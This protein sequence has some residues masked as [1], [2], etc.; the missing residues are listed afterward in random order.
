[1][2]SGMFWHEHSRSPTTLFFFI[3]VHWMYCCVYYKA[4]VLFACSLLETS[5]FCLVSQYKHSSSI[6]VYW[7]LWGH[8]K[9]R[10]S[11]ILGW[12]LSLACFVLLTRH[13]CQGLESFGQQQFPTCCFFLSPPNRPVGATVTACL[14]CAVS[15]QL[16]LVC[17]SDISFL[18]MM[19][20]LE[21]W[22]LQSWRILWWL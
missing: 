8:F 11:S 18:C 6:C 22:V 14:L 21:S 4:K 5:F 19:P 7:G 9:S 15:C 17:V 13:K 2:H 1:M 12:G 10:Y 3:Y 20:V 16:L